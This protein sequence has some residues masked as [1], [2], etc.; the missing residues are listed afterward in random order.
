MADGRVISYDTARTSNCV[1]K[2][3]DP[4]YSSGARGVIAKARV[5]CTGPYG[6]IPIMIQSYLGRT[7]KNS[8]KTLVVVK[9]SEYTQGVVTNSGPT[10]WY[11]PKLGEQGAP[12][13][14]YFRA[15][16]AGQSAPPLKTFYTKGAGSNFKWVP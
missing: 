15:S 6:T 14:A 8:I 1:G 7:N 2:Q 13:G 5:S 9:E 4:H 11:V 3:D 10:T 12:R 16:H